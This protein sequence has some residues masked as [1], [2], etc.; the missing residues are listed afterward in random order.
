MSFILWNNASSAVA[1]YCR[2]STAAS[3]SEE[4]AME[5]SRALDKKS[6]VKLLGSILA[7][8]MTVHK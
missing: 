8:Q 4:K 2:L 3:Q 1:V 7:E 5:V 6:A